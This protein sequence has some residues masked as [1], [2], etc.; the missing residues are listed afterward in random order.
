[1]V[2]GW[3]WGCHCTRYSG[4]HFEVRRLEVGRGCHFT[5]GCEKNCQ[6]SDGCTAFGPASFSLF[7][8]SDLP[9]SIMQAEPIASCNI[10]TLTANNAL[11]LPTAKGDGQRAVASSSHGRV[12]PA[13]GLNAAIGQR[14]HDLIG[15]ETGVNGCALSTPRLPRPGDSPKQDCT[16]SRSMDIHH[17]QCRGHFG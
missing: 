7:H 8:L 1:M 13:L 11:V 14:S 4:C 9:P 3:E 15:I 2:R 17:L 12:Q 5:L 6:P 16:Q 10:M